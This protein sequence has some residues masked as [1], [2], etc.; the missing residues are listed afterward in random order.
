MVLREL[1]GKENEAVA[2]RPPPELSTM[3]VVAVTTVVGTG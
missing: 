2:L 1:V 3:P